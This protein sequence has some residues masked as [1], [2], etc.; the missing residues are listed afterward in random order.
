MSEIDKIVSE[1]VDID[2][3]K[4]WCKNIGRFR[5]KNANF[6][7]E[8]STGSGKVPHAIAWVELYMLPKFHP[9]R[10]TCTVVGSIFFIF[11]I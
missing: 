5:P 6:R 11:G 2:S 8:L 3:G 9:N 10:L 7:F 1:W 4:N